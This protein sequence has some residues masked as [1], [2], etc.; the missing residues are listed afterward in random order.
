MSRTSI[1]LV[2]LLAMLVPAPEL[3]MGTTELL[4]SVAVKVTAYTLE[5]LK[6]S[7]GITASGKQPR[8]GYIAISR[9]LELKHGLGFGDKVFINGLGEFEIQDRTHFRKKQLVDVYMDCYK[10]AVQFGVKKLNMVFLKK[11][12]ET[13]D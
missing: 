9:D 11:P 5:E 8:T 10:S 6:S 12:G 13:V 7:E 3:G 1:C 4:E 2:T